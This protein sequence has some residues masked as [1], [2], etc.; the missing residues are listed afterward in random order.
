MSIRLLLFLLLPQHIHSSCPDLCSG[1]GKCGSGKRERD[2][3]TCQIGYIGL[4]CANKECLFGYQWG[5]Q[6]YAN[7][8]RYYSECSNVG[9]CDRKTGLCDCMPGFTGAGCRRQICP[10][11]CSG[12]GDCRYVADL[13]TDISPQIEGRTDRKYDMWDG[14]KAQACKCD[15]MYTGA[16]C[17]LR[18][19]ARGDDPLTNHTNWHELATGGVVKVHVQQNEVQKLMLNGVNDVSGNFVL[20]YIDQFNETWSTRP[21]RVENNVGTTQTVSLVANNAGSYFE[22]P[23]YV[24]KMLNTWG[25]E[26]TSSP[27]GGTSTYYCP[28]NDPACQKECPFGQGY[29]FGDRLY[30]TGTTSQTTSI[31]FVTAATPCRLTVEPAPVT[32]TIPQIT[33]IK[34]LSSGTGI[35]PLIGRGGVLQALRALPNR[36]IPDITVTERI[37][38]NSKKE[39]D[40]TFNH[41]DNSGDQRNIRCRPHGC[42]V[43]GCQPRYQGLRKSIA[44]I[45]INADSTDL[46][47]QY[48]TFTSNSGVAD[49]TISMAGSNVMFANRLAVG[50]IILVEGTT[51]NTGLSYTIN[52]VSSNTI[53]VNENVVAETYT[54]GLVYLHAT[55][56]FGEGSQSFDLSVASGLTEHY[57][58]GSSGWHSIARNNRISY[59]ILAS[60]QVE[61]QSSSTDDTFDDVM[62][63]DVISLTATSD[64][65]WN[66]FK[67]NEFEVVAIDT[68]VHIVHPLNITLTT[69]T[70]AFRVVREAGSCNVTEMIKGTKEMALCGNRGNCN[71]N[72]GLCECFPGYHGTSCSNQETLV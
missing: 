50:D 12:H 16:D 48:L 53:T 23:T 8:L 63:G 33:S 45:A 39:F 46:Y 7:D 3:C 52:A 24:Q 56:L 40:I 13:A 25:S 44:T 30:I 47:D 58:A 43:D 22:G 14:K 15:P 51:L 21:I 61:F 54:S 29:K 37:R 18:T 69:A 6:P 71:A 72:T 11:Q 49:D 28:F 31:F 20:E 9:V 27:G 57:A 68:E 36:V 2:K 26:A 32:T 19:C 4:N 34:L 42:D 5:G 70:S 10:N 59:D 64:S 66:G 38:S 65:A 35:E 17:S 41:Q 67:D 60:G 55:R 62:V 1:H